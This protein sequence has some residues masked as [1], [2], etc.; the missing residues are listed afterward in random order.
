MCANTIEIDGEEYLMKGNPT[1]R[2]VRVVQNM[3]NKMLRDHIDESKLA[4]MEDMGEE[5]IVS[6]IL[7]SGGYDAFEDVMWE[8]SLLSPVQTISLA[9]DHAFDTDDFEEVP[10]LQFKEMREKAEEALG[11][12]VDDFFKDLG[13]GMS[14]SE[15]E[16]KRLQAQQSNGN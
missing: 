14:L 13:I 15:D 16:M 4:Q 7:D 9:A 8:K 12:D 10:A 1:L 3:Q 2:T 11:G 5:E 6:A